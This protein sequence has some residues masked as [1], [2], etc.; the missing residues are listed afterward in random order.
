M[1]DCRDDS[2]D[3]RAGKSEDETISEQDPPHPSEDGE[4]FLQRWSRR[5]HRAARSE[6]QAETAQ[7]G[8]TPDE[9]AADMALAPAE[10]GSDS[11]ASATESPEP[12]PPGD[13]DMPPLDSIDQGG[14][15]RDFFS[16]NVSRKLRGAALKRLFSQPEFSAP[17]LLEEYAGDYSKP[18]PLGDT[19][20]AEMRYRA[21]QALKFAERKL[22]AAAEQAGEDRS[23]AARPP[24][25]VPEAAGHDPRSAAVDADRHPNSAQAPK[26]ASAADSES[27]ESES[28]E[29]G[30]SEDADA[31][32]RPEAPDTTKPAS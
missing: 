8:R 23:P 9:T 32:S 31:A 24:A 12:E 11:E 27:A 16:P 15:V 2:E 5:K 22:K 6:Q 19:V 29:T 3:R 21:E 1:S 26:D 20:T 25:A 30:P 18:T 7:S 4:S 17:D 10:I 13:E 28:S 14:S